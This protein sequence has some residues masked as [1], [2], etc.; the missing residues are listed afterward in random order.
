[1]NLFIYHS[2]II[3]HDFFL[4]HAGE[5]DFFF[6]LATFSIKKSCFG[7]LTKYSRFWTLLLSA[8]AYGA[9]L[10]L[11]GATGHGAKFSAAPAKSSDAREDETLAPWPVAPSSVT[12]ALCAMALSKRVQKRY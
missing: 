5:A 4:E 8:I 12:S 2:L 6:N 3:V 11:L 1:M 9:E 10:T 7:P